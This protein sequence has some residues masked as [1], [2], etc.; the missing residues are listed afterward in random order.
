MAKFR[1]EG[2]SVDYTPVA[3]VAA[4]TAVLLGTEWIGVADNDIKAN[5]KGAL[6]TCGIF[7]FIGTFA[8]PIAQGTQLRIIMASGRA[9]TTADAAGNTTVKLYA[10]DPIPIGTDIKIRAYINQFG[11]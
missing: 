10:A 8:A 1:A 2:K 7:E 3:D 5:V 9:T 11:G 6:R 4:G